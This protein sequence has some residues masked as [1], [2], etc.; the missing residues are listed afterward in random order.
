M[1]RRTL[2]VATAVMAVVLMPVA[3]RAADTPAALTG[4]KLVTADD[5]TKLES[6]GAVVVDTRVAS[7]FGEAHIKGAVSI[8][9]RE[10]SAKAV[11]FDA[12]ED[13]FALAK[14]PPDKAAA[15]VMYCNG[16]DCWKSFKASTAA[17]KGGYTNIYWY[18]DG[19]PDWKSKG[20]PVE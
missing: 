3:V 9:Y 13:S 11:D 8:P 4:T 18:R 20:R 19:F 6:A 2:L 17:V 14:L 1:Q 16:P 7:E 15:I 12:H 10:K 5:V